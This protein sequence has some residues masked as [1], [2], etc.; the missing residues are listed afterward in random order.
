METEDQRNPSMQRKTIL[1]V[2]AILIVFNIGLF[3]WSVQRDT[4]KAAQSAAQD[5]QLTN[6]VEQ[7]DQN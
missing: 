1:W 4:K 5:S 6:E 3:L 7:V 2:A